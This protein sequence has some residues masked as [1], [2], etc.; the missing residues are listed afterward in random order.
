M[1]GF[2]HYVEIPVRYRDL[3]PMNHVNNSVYGTYLEE[4]R[5]AYFEDVL[6]VRLDECDVVIA[7]IELQF[8]HPVSEGD[9]VVAVYTRVPSLGSSSLPFE[10]EI[11]GND[12]RK[13]T[14]R[15]TLVRVDREA[16]TAEPLPNAWRE[17]VE[18]YE[19]L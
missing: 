15:T 12:E 2:E 8:E 17:R 7:N 13:A 16:E 9:V 18:A 10:Y 3:D 14:G 11:R 4:G 1:D 19:G 6:G 5:A